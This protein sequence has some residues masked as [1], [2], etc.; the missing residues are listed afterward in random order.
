[1]GIN[2][3]SLIRGQNDL[4]PAHLD[5]VPVTSDHALKLPP[6]GRTDVAN[7]QAHDESP[8]VTTTSMSTRGNPY[9]PNEANA[10]T[11]YFNKC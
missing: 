6:L 5:P 9:I 3:G 4:R 2:L 8:H 7:V 1:M 11:P 10:Q